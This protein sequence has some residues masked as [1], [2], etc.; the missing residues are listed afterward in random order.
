MTE[1]LENVR[2]DKFGQ[3]VALE[4]GREMREKQ[5]NPKQISIHSW[6]R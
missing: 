2:Q 3:P 5:T 4:G 6:A 1:Y